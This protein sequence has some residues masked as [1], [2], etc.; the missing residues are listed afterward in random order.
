M[1]RLLIDD[2]N[3]GT[4][5]LLER[6]AIG[7]PQFIQSGSGIVRSPGSAEGHRRIT[8]YVTSNFPNHKL[9]ASVRN[10]L[11]V[12]GGYKV[13]T[14]VDLDYGLNRSGDI[15]SLKLNA[16]AYKNVQI[17]FDGSDKVINFAIQFHSGGGYSQ[18]SYNIPASESPFSKIVPLSEFPAPSL[19]TVFSWKSIDRIAV[20][21]QH[22]GPTLGNDFGVRRIF[23][24]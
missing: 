1:G 9:M 10:G 17:D 14:R 16:A 11:W 18:Y 13:S 4:T 24:E 3:T 7:T 23:L 5:D 6:Q 22:T 19:P 2:F 21:F 20:I 15:L 12:S 8:L